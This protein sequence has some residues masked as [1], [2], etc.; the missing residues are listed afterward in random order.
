MFESAAPHRLGRYL[1]THEVA[2][3]GMGKVYIGRVDGPKGFGKLVA[4]KLMHEYLADGE[5]AD[6]FADEARVA[7]RIHHPNVC[8]V[9]DFGEE[10]GV[11]YLVMELL[12]GVPISRVL[13]HLSTAYAGVARPAAYFAMV[14]RIMA[15]A[16]AGL[17]AVHEI[18]DDEGRPLDIVHRDVSPENLFI[19]Y[20]GAVRIVDFGIA[21][22][23]GRIHQTQVGAFKGKL[24]YAAPEQLRGKTTRTADIWSAGAVLWELLTLRCAFDRPSEMETV[25]AVTCL[26]VADPRT[27]ASDVP[28]ALA[29]IALRALQRDP[30]ARY[31]TARDMARELAAY[32]LQHG[33]IDPTDVAMWVRSVCHAEHQ[34][35][36]ALLAE[37]RAVGRPSADMVW[38]DTVFDEPL[39]APRTAEPS[40]VHTVLLRPSGRQVPQDVARPE[41]VPSPPPPSPFA[42]GGSTWVGTPAVVE[43]RPTRLGLVVMLVLAAAATLAGAIAGT[44]C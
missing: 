7:S 5:V 21:A 6:M 36:Q 30:Q 37:A 16:L 25:T 13:L 3:G 40:G 27:I 26:P 9:Y 32:A 18:T 39:P 38:A 43:R 20:D 42:D 12:A 11:F 31:P 44:A 15:D 8:Q 17:H 4:V 34:E 14:A 24:A 33:V 29:A 23:R 2:A 35:S 28:P 1:L 10:D 41:E 22:G 19:T